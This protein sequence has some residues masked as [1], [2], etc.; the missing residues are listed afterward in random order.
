ME[1]MELKL[2][3]VTSLLSWIL[4]RL[5]VSESLLGE[6]LH[7]NTNRLLG[8]WL[9]SS[10]LVRRALFACFSSFV[11]PIAGLQLSIGKLRI[12]DKRVVFNAGRR[13]LKQSLN[14]MPYRKVLL[15]ADFFKE[16]CTN[17][18]M[19]RGRKALSFHFYELFSFQF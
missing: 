11:C 18:R 7:L 3:F 8:K 9:R 4:L 15:E 17:A 5:G 14:Q 16:F 2:C 12:V 6:C 10:S 13:G 19:L 1:G